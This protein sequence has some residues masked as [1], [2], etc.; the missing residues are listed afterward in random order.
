MAYPGFLK[1]FVFDAGVIPP[2]LKI[3]LLCPDRALKYEAID[4]LRSIA[5]RREGMW[6]SMV[7]ADAGEK[8]IAMEDTTQELDM[9]D[10]FLLEGT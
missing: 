8:C 7:C 1:G 6:D 3:V 10:P 4:V 2:L 9:I 5:P